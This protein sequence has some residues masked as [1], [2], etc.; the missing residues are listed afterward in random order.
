MVKW[1]NVITFKDF[2]IL[3][4][5]VHILNLRATTINLIRLLS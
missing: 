3:I 2:E 5:V 1:L 4:L